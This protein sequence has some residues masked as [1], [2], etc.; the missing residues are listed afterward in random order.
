MKTHTHTHRTLSYTNT[1][2]KLSYTNTHT[3]Q[4]LSYTNTQQTF[5]YTNTHIK[6]YLTQTH[7]HTPN[8]LLQKHTRKHNHLRGEK[9]GRGEGLAFPAA[10]RGASEELNGFMQSSSCL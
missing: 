10:P 8:S 7:S 1:H 6:L 2:I 4:T 5:S 3:L 9:L